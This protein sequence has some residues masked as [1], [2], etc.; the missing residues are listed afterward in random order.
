MVVRSTLEETY[1]HVSLIVSNASV[2]TLTWS[3]WSAGGCGWAAAR[4]PPAGGRAPGSASPRP[5]TPRSAPRPRPAAP[6]PRPAP[7]PSSAMSKSCYYLSVRSSPSVWSSHKSPWSHLTTCSGAVTADVYKCVIVMASHWFHS[8]VI[9]YNYHPWNTELES[10]AAEQSS[11]CNSRSRYVVD[12]IATWQYDTP[13]SRRCLLKYRLHGYKIWN[14]QKWLCSQS[15]CTN[16]S[17]VRRYQSIISTI[18]P[19]TLRVGFALQLKNH[20]DCNRIVFKIVTGIMFW[21]F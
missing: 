16:K 14:L 20:F 8:L 7:P 13:M 19:A 11:L 1:F 18:C 21:I 10:M 15:V 2:H 12:T 9:I 3:L 6:P 5:A 17:S 4:G